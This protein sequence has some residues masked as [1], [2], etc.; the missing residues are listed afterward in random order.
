MGS[1]RHQ[2]RRPLL[3]SGIKDAGFGT[4]PRLTIMGH[5][6]RLCCYLFSGSKSVV[7][8]PR[9]ITQSRSVL[10]L[11]IARF[12]TL[13]SSTKTA[14]RV[15]RLI[16]F[17]PIVSNVSHGW[18]TWKLCNRAV[19]QSQMFN[20]ANVSRAIAPARSETEPILLWTLIGTLIRHY[21]I[22]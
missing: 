18:T 11:K 10:S 9:Q 16:L 22:F 14:K 13:F 5:A 21:G 12:L 20:L 15:Q 17:H 19:V 7:D 4:V 2:M 8:P 3:A 6:I 1:L